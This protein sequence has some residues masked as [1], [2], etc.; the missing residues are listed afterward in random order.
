MTEPSGD[1]PR[2]LTPEQQYAWRR[3]VEVLVKVPAALEA[4]LQRDAGL[5][6]MG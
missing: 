2:W 1:G 6:H 5:A 4:Q 3:V